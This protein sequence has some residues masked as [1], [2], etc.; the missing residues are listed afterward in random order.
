MKYK[1]YDRSVANKIVLV[2]IGL[3]AVIAVI[4]C[5]KVVMDHI[6]G[7]SSD[8]DAVCENEETIREINESGVYGKGRKVN[9]KKKTEEN[10]E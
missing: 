7:T 9:C 8:D 1:D 2:V 5:V 6:G 10:E 4:A 3:I